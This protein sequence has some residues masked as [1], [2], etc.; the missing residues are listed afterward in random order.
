MWIMSG[1]G[2]VRC[3]WVMSGEGGARCGLCLGRVGLSED[4]FKFDKKKDEVR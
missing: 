2:G 1:E 4:G 3:S